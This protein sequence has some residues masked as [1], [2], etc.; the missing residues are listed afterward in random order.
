[1]K[2]SNTVLYLLEKLEVNFIILFI[3]NIAQ[4]YRIELNLGQSFLSRYKN[5]N[6]TSYFYGILCDQ[7]YVL[8]FMLEIIRSSDPRLL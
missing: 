4:Y 8:N 3:S 6:T 2:C 1:M 5:C 7:K